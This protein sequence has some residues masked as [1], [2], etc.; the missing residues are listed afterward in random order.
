MSNVLLCHLLNA[1]AVGLLK[2][3]RRPFMFVYQNEKD[4]VERAV[5]NLG[6]TQV[7]FSEETQAMIRVSWKESKLVDISWLILFLKKIMLGHALKNVNGV[8]L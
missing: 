4:H 7:E 1:V 3:V 2:V 5:I 8:L 6:T